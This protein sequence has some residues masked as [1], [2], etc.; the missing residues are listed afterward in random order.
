L[1]VVYANQ[2]VLN[3]G[4]VCKTG[5]ALVIKAGMAG[6]AISCRWGSLPGS[7]QDGWRCE[8]Q[9]S[10]VGEDCAVPV[11]TDC[12]DGLDNDNDGLADCDDPECCASSECSREAVCA[13]VPAPV[14]VLLRLPSVQ[15]AD[16][17]QLNSSVFLSSFETTLSK[18]IQI[19]PNLME[20]FVGCLGGMGMITDW[21]FDSIKVDVDLFV[22]FK[23]ELPRLYWMGTKFLTIISVIRGRVVWNGGASTESSNTVPLPG[24]RVSDAVNPLYGF[25]LTRL[26]GEFDL[27][28]NGGRTVNLQFLRSPFQRIKRSVYVPP[29][30]IVVVDSIKMVREE[31]GIVLFVGNYSFLP[32]FLEDIY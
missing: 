7:T 14:D 22:G 2:V 32:F 3:M 1:V 28:V 10:F 11:E 16:F 6:I 5:P 27:L 20:D 19:I 13:T 30:E 31:V 15:N 17:F 8:C 29:N 23:A 24:V 4:N 21:L 9:P 12:Q 26:D 25:T 18:A